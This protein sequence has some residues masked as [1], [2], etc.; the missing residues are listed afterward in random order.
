MLR[1]YIM[2]FAAVDQGNIQDVPADQI[3]QVIL[4]AT[5]MDDA[6]QR[7]LQALSPEDAA[8]IQW[9]DQT[10]ELPE[11]EFYEVPFEGWIEQPA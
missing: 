1:T 2:S 4:L 5:H 7:I 6:K 11:G 9:T 10:R 3:K 8:T